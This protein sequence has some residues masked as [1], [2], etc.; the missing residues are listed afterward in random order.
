MADEY[1]PNAQE[2]MSVN[3]HLYSPNR[4]IPPFRPPRERGAPSCLDVRHEG[5]N[6][7][8]W[9]REEGDGP[10]AGGI[11]RDRFDASLVVLTVHEESIL[12]EYADGRTR[13]VDL[14]AWRALRARPALF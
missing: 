8:R 1:D 11:Y 3:S 7:V 13:V 12:I 14:V 5:G 10:V 9:R 6:G 2:T 4:S